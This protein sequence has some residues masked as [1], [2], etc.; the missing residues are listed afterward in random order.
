ML[1]FKESAY[2]ENRKHYEGVD[3]YLVR[4]YHNIY[5][6]L[7]EE[8]IEGFAPSEVVSYLYRN[9]ESVPSEERISFLSSFFNNSLKNDI[10]IVK[11]WVSYL[12]THMEER[13]VEDGEMM[14]EYRSNIEDVPLAIR[15]EERYEVMVFIENILRNLELQSD[16]I[17]RILNDVNYNNLELPDKEFENYE[18]AEEEFE[19]RAYYE[20]RPRRYSI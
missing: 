7:E 12:D 20:Q 2:I 16:E 10:K 15:G 13:Y 17:V 4:E 14:I 5:N 1:L 9:M 19:D 6:T 3:D 18:P 11:V 8:D